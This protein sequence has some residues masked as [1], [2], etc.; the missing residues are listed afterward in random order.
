MN[1]RRNIERKDFFKE[2]PLSLLRAFLE[3]AGKESTP[4]FPYLYDGPILRPPGAAPEHNFLDTR[5]GGSDC[6]RACPAN[7]IRMEPRGNDLLRQA[8]IIRPAEAA[9]VL[10]DELACMK[11]CPSGAITLLPREEIQIGNTRVEDEKCLSWQGEE[12]KLCVDKCPVGKTAIWK[13]EEES[14]LSP[15]VGDGCVG[16]GLCEYYCPVLPAAI[17]VFERDPSP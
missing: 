7:A 10:C 1:A 5:E 8:P 4:N 6:A 13:K 12:C 9:C 2:G 11:V 15:A 16:C 17:R 3:G 14:R